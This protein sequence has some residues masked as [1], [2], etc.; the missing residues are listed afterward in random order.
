MQRYLKVFFKGE[1]FNFEAQ[2]DYDQNIRHC[3]Y[4]LD[5]DLIMLGLLSHDPHFALLREEV[6][7]GRTSKQK[8]KEY[9]LGVVKTDSR[10]ESQNFFLLHLSIL[11]EYLELEFD[12]LSKSL[13]FTYDFERIIDDFILLTFFVGNDFLPNL[14]YLHINEGALAYMFDIYKRVLPSCG[15]YIN[16]A[17]IINLDRLEIVLIELEKMEYEAFEIDQGNASW[18]KAKQSGD[19]EEERAE[20]KTLVLT[21]YQ[22]SLVKE[23][24]KFTLYSDDDD[25]DFPPTLNATDRKFVQDL[26]TVL[27]L[28]Y[29]TVTNEDGEKHLQIHFKDD[30]EPEEEGE[31]AMKRIFKKYERAQVSE[32]SVEEAEAAMDRKY[33]EKFDEWKDEYYKVRNPR[34]GELTGGRRSCIF[35][36]TMRLLLL[37]LRRITSMDCSGCYYIIIA[38]FLLGLGFIDTIIP[39]KLRVLP[40][41]IWVDERCAQRIQS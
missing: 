14:P 2:P 32:Q 25:L 17:G 20:K 31:D 19:Y 41:K 37:T 10:L 11:R 26:V 23:V 21:P 8:S 27:G 18:L 28:E 29:R 22:K 1:T 13:N 7:F 12:T 15:G 30:F 38:A 5:A 4:G 16:E 40:Q 34:S 33:N 24:K 39:L 35:R 6:T 9:Q 36:Y 3:L